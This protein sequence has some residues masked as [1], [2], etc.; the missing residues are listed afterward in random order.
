MGHIYCGTPQAGSDDRTISGYPL[1]KRGY[2]ALPSARE[3][4]R[5]LF[6]C[7]QEGWRV[8]PH[9]RS[10]PTQPLSQDI[11]IQDADV[12]TDHDF[13]WFFTIDLKD[14]YVHV[15]ILPNT[16]SSLGLLLDAKHTNG[17]SVRSS[18][19]NPHFHHVCG[20]VHE[21]CQSRPVTYCKAV[22]ETVGSDGSSVQRDTFWPAVHETP[23]CFFLS[24]LGLRPGE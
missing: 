20:H 1:E 11:Q 15:S 19:V 22:S 9:H 6:N 17:S 10:A 2:R 3:G 21:Q 4:V 24:R 23:R 18:T 16:G 13:F 12:E 14:A 8:A 5:T 7:S